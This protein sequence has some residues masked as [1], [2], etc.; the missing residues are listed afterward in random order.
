[1][2]WRIPSALPNQVPTDIGMV[3]LSDSIESGPVTDHNTKR[4]DRFVILSRAALIPPHARTIFPCVQFRRE[5]SRLAAWAPEI[6]RRGLAEQWSDWQ[7]AKFIDD[8]DNAEFKLL[9]GEADSRRDPPMDLEI[10]MRFK[11]PSYFTVD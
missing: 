2:E 1:M 9:Y 7:R 6:P 11:I 3:S 8:S 5:A 10:E 4:D